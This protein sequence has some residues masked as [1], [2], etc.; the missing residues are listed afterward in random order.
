[1]RRESSSP[2]FCRPDLP[3]RASPRRIATGLAAASRAPSC[4]PPPSSAFCKTMTRS[5]IGRSASVSSCS[6]PRRRSTQRC[7]SCCSRRCRRCCSWERNG[8]RC[9]HFRSSAI[10][11]ASL[12][13]RCDAAARR[14]S[15]RPIRI[16]PSWRCRIRWRKRRFA[17]PCSTGAR[18][19]A[20]R[21][22]SGW[23]SSENCSHCAAETLRRVCK[24]SGATTRMPTGA[25]A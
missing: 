6:H 11:P 5:E 22:R 1:M 24:L 8:A 15:R 19:I 20:R 16:S 7:K 3:I 14:S 2:G 12:P 17:P 23:R 4:R 21:T 10:S 25:T 9:S 13:T 18:S